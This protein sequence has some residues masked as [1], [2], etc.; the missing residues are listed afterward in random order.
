MFQTSGKR[1]L[2]PCLEQTFYMVLMKKE[3]AENQTKNGLF[4]AEVL[5]GI[6]FIN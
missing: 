3:P 5:L 2:L 1:K 6:V 4:Y